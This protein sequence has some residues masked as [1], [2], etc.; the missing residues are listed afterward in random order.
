MVNQN[1]LSARYA[2]EAMNEVFSDVGKI[3][4]ERD[5]WLSVMKAQRELGIDIPTE[6]IE[7]YAAARDKVD[8]ERIK[9]IETKRRHEVKAKIEAFTEAAGVEPK[10]QHLH[11][12][13]TSRDLD[14]N[15]WQYQIKK[16]SE[17]VFGKFVS[18]L[19]HFVDM[20][21]KYGDL[22]ITAR[23]H[24]QPA[25]PTVLGRRM[26]MWAEELYGHLADFERFIQDYPLRGIKGPVGT[27][28][29]MLTL[30]GSQEKVARLEEI[31]ARELGF[32]RTLSAPGQVYA[33]SLDSALISKLAL[34]SAAP[35]NY[36]N[37]MRLMARGELVTEGFKEGQ[38]GSSAMPHKINA[39][40]AERIWSLSELLK[41]YADGASRI[42]GAQWEEGDV[43][44][45]AIRRVIIPDAFYTADGVCET[46]LTVLN[47]MVAF[48]A[49]INAELDRYLPFLATTEI[50][51]TAVKA[52][53]GREEA[54]EAIRKYSVQAALD[55]REGKIP[56]FAQSLANDPV[57]KNHGIQESDITALLKDR[58][59]FIGNARIQIADVAERA[60]Y[61]LE[62]YSRQA[63]YEPEIIL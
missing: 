41:T 61:F 56:R 4:L 49:V 44:D 27:Q 59:H 2:T 21:R 14:D 18:I 52:G 12:G 29:D 46:T 28:F 19:R 35:Q 63:A 60:R 57:F 22:I 26:A 7:K 53:I 13:M 15:V 37:T 23:T 36:S 24:M 40:S 9:E 42:S 58:G 25:Q 6:T 5:L 39:R 8:L 54:H 3:P 55:I 34:L 45:S 38:V 31:V 1:I 10:E 16:A 32:S 50:L 20:S 48:P 30:L 47:E 51:M 62:K 43:S 33:R 17:I 11:K